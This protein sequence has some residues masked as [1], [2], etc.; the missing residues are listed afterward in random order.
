M[1]ALLGALVAVYLAYLILVYP[2]F[3]SLRPALSKENFGI[4]WQLDIY[5]ED[6]VISLV[7][8]TPTTPLVLLNM[9]L[10]EV[11]QETPLEER[12]GLLQNL[13]S[14]Y[15][16]VVTD[17]RAIGLAHLLPG[18]PDY[19]LPELDHAVHLAWQTRKVIANQNEEE[20]KH[21]IVA[22]PLVAKGEARI[23]FAAYWP[24]RK[25]FKT[26]FDLVNQQFGIIRSQYILASEVSAGSLAQYDDPW[27]DGEERT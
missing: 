8:D 24:R 22:L 11:L 16:P 15:I 12:L 25:P 13:W 6:K 14:Q 19:G 5:V 23:V 10:A 21:N 3:S 1:L 20:R 2:F 27:N 17:R 18:D 7:E 4:D 9:G 26:T